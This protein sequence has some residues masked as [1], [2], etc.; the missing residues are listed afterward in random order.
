MIGSTSATRPIGSSYRFAPGWPG[1]LAAPLAAITF[2]AI[3][4]LEARP[5][6]GGRFGGVAGCAAKL[7]SQAGLSGSRGGE[8]GT[9]LHDF[10]IRAIIKLTMALGV[11]SQHASLIPEGVALIAINLCLR[12][13]WET[14]Y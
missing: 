11:V 12:P 6:A 4:R 2:A 3:G 8:L 9:Q 10:L 13:I 7:L 14:G 1:W 5:I